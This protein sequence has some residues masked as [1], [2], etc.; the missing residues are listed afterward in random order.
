[1]DGPPL[2]QL[3]Y[4]G[5]YTNVYRDQ[6]TATSCRFQAGLARAVF[7]APEQVWSEEVSDT[8]PSR[9]PRNWLPRCQTPV[10][11][12]CRE[13]S[14]VTPER[15]AAPSQPPKG[16]HD[17]GLR[18]V[19]QSPPGKSIGRVVSLN[20]MP[21]AAVLIALLVVDGWHRVGAGRRDAS[22][23]DLGHRWRDRARRVRAPRCDRLVLERSFGRV[24]LLPACRAASMPP[25]VGRD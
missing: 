20:A 14:G 17:S 18:I 25:E 6:R 11:V 5:S 13:C 10:R 2:Y 1:M 3:S 19:P 7:R 23:C 12:P 4:P 15:E 16:S 9:R 8:F 22:R 21:R 24:L